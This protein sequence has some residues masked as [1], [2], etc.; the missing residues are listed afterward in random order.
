MSH[1]LSYPDLILG[2]ALHH[3]WMM[4]TGGP[5]QPTSRAPVPRIA[6]CLNKMGTQHQLHVGL[7]A[8]MY[9]CMYRPKFYRTSL[10]VSSECARTDLFDSQC[11][12][13]LIL[14]R[15]LH[16]LWMMSAEGLLQPTSRLPVPQIALCLNKARLLVAGMYVCGYNNLKCRLQDLVYLYKPK[17]QHQWHVQT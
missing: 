11:P 7:Y 10:F 13:G 17:T 5:L 2:R 6:L 9:V 1:Q 4:S 16:P 14:E 12:S 8:C 15:S 3:L